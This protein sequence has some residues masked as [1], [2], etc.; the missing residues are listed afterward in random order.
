MFNVQELA[1]VT[2][3]PTSTVYYWFWSYLRDTPYEKHIVQKIDRYL[4][5]NDTAVELMKLIRDFREKGVKGKKNIKEV[6]ASYFESKGYTLSIAEKKEGDSTQHSN[7]LQT[8]LNKLNYLEKE[9]HDLKSNKDT[10]QPKGIFRTLFN[11]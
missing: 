2:G 4:Y 6:V 1:E 8:I 10:E 11:K 3:K 7:T 9:I 5:F